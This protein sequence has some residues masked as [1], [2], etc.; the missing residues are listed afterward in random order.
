[1]LGLIS[2][3][4]LLLCT[5]IPYGSVDALLGYYLIL[6]NTAYCVF[7]LA[8]GVLAIV[9]SLNLFPKSNVLLLLTGVL[10]VIAVFAEG[11]YIFY[12]SS[13][14]DSCSMEAGYVLSFFGAFGII[15][16]GLNNVIESGKKH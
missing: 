4:L 13:L 6:I 14:A 3:A 11:Y 5:M 9:F 15:G 8:I 7:F 2:G 1:M 16:A 10:A 12:S